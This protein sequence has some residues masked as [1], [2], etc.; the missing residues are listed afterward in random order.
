MENIMSY[1]GKW[2]CPACGNTWVGSIGWTMP[3]DLDAFLTR[4]CG[5]TEDKLTEED[6]AG[7]LTMSRMMPIPK[8]TEED[9]TKEE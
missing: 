4:I 8:K 3:K 7:A 9:Q 1:F 6:W 5:C 2:E